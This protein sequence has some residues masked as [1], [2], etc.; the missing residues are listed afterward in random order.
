MAQTIQDKFP[1]LTVKTN[2]SLAPLSTFKIGGPAQIFTITKSS[3]QLKELLVFVK[4]DH[5]QLPLTILGNASNTLISDSGIEGLVIKNTSQ[6]IHILKKKP[7]E[8]K[9]QLIPVLRQEK[10][11]KKYLDF[12]SLNYDE[13]DKEKVFVEIES[14]VPFPYAISH[15]LQKGVTGLQWFAGI[16]GTVGGATWYNLHGGSY[17]LSDFIHSV[18]VLD[19]KNSTV[20]KMSPKDLNFAY[21]YSLL[22]KKPNL[23]ILSTT[24]SLYKGNIEKAQSTAQKWI[25]QKK[26][27]QPIPSAGSVFKNLSPDLAQKHGFESSSVGW[28][29]DQKLKLKGKTIGSAQI[30]PLHANFIVNTGSAK[31]K[32]VLSLIKLVQKE[33]KNRWNIKLEPEIKILDNV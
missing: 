20:K 8:S 2:W 31:A 15:L 30:S 27:V 33:F 12:N 17:H 13:S 7:P 11:S 3:N 26:K 9:K 24:L 14:G 10:D 19:L 29:I 21:D 5:P 25:E 22:Q 4:K 6:N 1:D 32:D 23:I 18:E 28:I 16:P